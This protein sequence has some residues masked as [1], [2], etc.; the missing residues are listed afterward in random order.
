MLAHL[1]CLQQ[2]LLITYIDLIK[3]MAIEE[4]GNI[5]DVDLVIENNLV[6]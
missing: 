4:L 6:V 1:F 2:K 5:L 3:E